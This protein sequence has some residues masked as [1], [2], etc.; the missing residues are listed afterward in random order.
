M[1]LKVTFLFFNFLR[2]FWGPLLVLFLLPFPKM[3]QRLKL[4]CTAFSPHSKAP[5]QLLVHVSSEGELEQVLPVLKRFLQSPKNHRVQ[6]LFTSPSVQSKV[7]ALS[8]KYPGKI[9]YRILPIFHYPWGLFW[10]G[11][12]LN[13]WIKAPV[14]LMV[15]YD[16]FPELVLALRSNAV[17][18]GLLSATLKG[19]YKA[20][21]NSRLKS[22]YWR[23]LMGQF[24]F[25]FCTTQRD[26]TFFRE[27]LVR[28]K[29]KVELDFFEFRVEQVLDRLAKAD[30]RLNG[31]F[32]FKN[33]E[34]F[35]QNYSRSQRI[36][37]GSAW[38]IDLE[39]LSHPQIVQCILHGKLGVFIAPHI[40][41][42][43][44]IENLKES[45][46]RIS[47]QFKIDILREE[48]NSSLFAPIVIS[49][50][51]GVLCEM[52]SLFDHIYIGGGFGR[53]IHSV[54]EPFW[55]GAHLYFG[56][57]VH[58][59]TE[60]DFVWERGP[61]QTHKISAP[62]DFFG[63]FESAPKDAR[64]R[65]AVIKERQE[66]GHQYLDNLESAF[67]LVGLD[68]SHSAC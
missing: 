3:R 47:S 14:C 18:L 40:I 46:L 7:E 2:I 28:Q 55:T 11:G 15:R 1:V 52:Y 25:I 6:I 38:E 64:L 9:D 50:V 58:R 17:K 27:L 59:S 23:S 22:W 48:E 12:S 5:A 51:P 44:F 33:L 19:K 20:L 60:Y 61:K 42:D 31:F 4:E 35:F 63:E 41:S 30:R 13:K 16:F 29:K 62:G 68:V 53:S 21:A 54:L 24:D 36:I 39:I 10:A 49:R 34:K 66:L 65:E 43:E 26:L 32:W 8:R 45:L 57:K 67:S 56:P 37:L